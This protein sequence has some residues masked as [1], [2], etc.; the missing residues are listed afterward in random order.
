MKNITYDRLKEISAA[1]D[2]FLG[3]GEGKAMADELIAIHELKGDQVPVALVD[4]RQGSGGFCLTQHGR[5][6][7][8][9]HGTELFT[10]PQKPVVPMAVDDDIIRDANRYRFL[11]DEDAW[12]EDS[13]SWDC[14]TRTGLISS[15]N[16]M[17]GLSPDH[18]DDAIDAR[19]AASD[20]PFLNPVTAPQKPVV[21]LTDCDIGAV[22]HMA[23]W[24]S[25]EQ[26]EAWVAGVE[27]AKKQIVAAGCIVQ[28]VDADKED[29][30]QSSAP[31]VLRDVLTAVSIGGSR[32]ELIDALTAIKP[33]FGAPGSRDVDVRA[34]HLAI[35][36]AIE[37]LSNL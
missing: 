10:A 12:G 3:R 35:D 21:V 24:Y 20:I 15:E 33:K 16:L 1:D 18:F 27:H 29:D 36:K 8:L 19:M 34:A 37:K 5:R 17:G 25:E 30:H 11:R 14:D 9:Q 6:L 13:D 2:G 32:T 22:S 28:T 4:E 31:A 26:C 23:H 7:N